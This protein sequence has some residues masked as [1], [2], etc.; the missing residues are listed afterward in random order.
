[1]PII[2]GPTKVWF[3]FKLRLDAEY[4]G[5]AETSLF[6]QQECRIETQPDVI[7]YGVES[8]DIDNV[9]AKIWVDWYLK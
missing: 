8:S 3:T 2:R 7:D 1:M 4:F 6:A 5:T 9:K